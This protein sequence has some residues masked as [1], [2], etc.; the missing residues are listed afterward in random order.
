MPTSVT[1]YPSSW[2]LSSPTPTL[3]LATPHLR[4]SQQPPLLLVT[5]YLR[6]PFH[7]CL[8][9]L[10]YL[11]S[12]IFK[13]LSS[14]AHHNCFI[15]PSS[16]LSAALPTSIAPS[17]HLQNSLQH[18]LP[19]LLHPP[20]FKTLCSIVYLNCSILPPSK[21]SAATPTPNFVN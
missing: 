5:S 4:N 10:H 13:T 18:C 14:N 12:L 8:S 19:Q 3:F 2:K 1:R 11:L 15:L 17:S 16:K 21:L 6:N 20:T 9:N 7:Q